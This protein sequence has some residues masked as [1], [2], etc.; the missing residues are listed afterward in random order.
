MGAGLAMV[1][2]L[3]AGTLIAQE[4]GATSKSVPA[5]GKSAR[6]PSRQVPSYFGQIGLTDE[7]RESIYKIRGKHMTKIDELE[8]Q[9]DEIQALMLDEC[10]GVLT[11][12]QKQMLAQRRKA[13]TEK[14]KGDAPEKS[15]KAQ[16]K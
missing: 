2:L 12:T 1:V 10:E 6:D 14:K 3:A 15:A 4:P 8:K 9:I 13:A 5:K 11:D 16:P 7:Q